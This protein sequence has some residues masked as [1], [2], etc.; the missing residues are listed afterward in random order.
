MFENREIAGKLLA[1]EIK[2]RY[3]NISRQE[4]I[5]VALPRGGVPIAKEIAKTL[6]LDMDIFFVK[7]IPSPFNKEA[8]IGA[9]SENGYFFVDERIKNLLNIDEVYIKNNIKEILEKIASKR[10]LY[11]KAKSSFKDKNVILVDDGVATG[12]S[13]ILAID[14]LKKEGAKKVIVAAPVAPLEVAT[15]LKEIADDAIFLLTPTNFNAVG[16]YYIDFH[17]LDDNEVIELLNN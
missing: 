4:Y 2:K 10:A 17:Q 9:V 11:N 1:Q 16:Q 7:K 5:V 13:M 14:A 3:P 12:S 6:D 8:A 15:R